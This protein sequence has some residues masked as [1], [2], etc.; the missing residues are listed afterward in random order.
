[1]PSKRGRPRNTQPA[2]ERDTSHSTEPSLISTEPAPTQQTLNAGTEEMRLL[3]HFM[4]RKRDSP[5]SSE[6]SNERDPLHHQALLLSS[7]YPCILHLIYEFSALELARQQPLRESFYRSL[8]EKHSVQGL[9]GATNLLQEMNTNDCHAIYTASVMAV[10]NFFAKGPQPGEYLFFGE[11][12]SPQWLPLLWGV[13]TIIEMVGLEK[14]TAGPLEETST[15]QSVQSVQADKP[16]TTLFKSPRLDWID[17]FDRLQAFVAASGDPDSAVDVDALQK[18]SWCYMAM[19]GKDDGTYQGNADQQN[20]FIWPYQ[21]NETFAQRIQDRKPVPLIITAH[22]ALLLQNYE[23]IWFM[24]GWSDHVL[25]AVNEILDAEYRVW[26]QWPISQARMIK[27][28]RKTTEFDTDGSTP[29][30]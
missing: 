12:G 1:M 4:T 5:G 26:L 7:T 18:L 30:A 14:I 19:Y 3:D 21:L 9:R 17:Y 27:E 24:R 28:A 23:F 20:L 22:F 11:H 13:R 8:A 6:S 10:M 29:K 25:V 15:E 16:G 2:P